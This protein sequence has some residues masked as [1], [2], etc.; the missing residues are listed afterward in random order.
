MQCYQTNILNFVYLHENSETNK[1]E[2][3]YS[4]YMKRA[5]LT[6]GIAF[7]GMLFAN[8]RVMPNAPSDELTSGDS[9][10]LTGGGGRE[11]PSWRQTAPASR[12]SSTIQ[13]AKSWSGDACGRSCSVFRLYKRTIKR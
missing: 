8:A 10:K 12:H 7:T 4:N 5:L 1:I 6:F 2:N 11:R 13:E 9:Y 3:Q